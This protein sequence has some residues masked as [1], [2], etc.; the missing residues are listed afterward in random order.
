MQRS[1]QLT[2]G[3]A[4]PPAALHCHRPSGRCGTEAPG[5]CHAPTGGLARRPEGR[6]GWW[7]ASST[8]RAAA[9]AAHTACVQADDRLQH[10]L[11]APKQAKSGVT[12]RNGTRDRQAPSQMSVEATADEHFLPHALQTAAR[13]GL[14]KHLWP[15]SNAHLLLTKRAYTTT[16]SCRQKPDMQ[17]GS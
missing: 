4:S 10:E 5:R 9:R 6:A 13:L 2:R 1:Q 16:T 11:G 12:H 7:R 15:Q 14:A 17:T 8:C 3:S